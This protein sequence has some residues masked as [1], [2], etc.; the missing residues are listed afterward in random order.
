[1]STAFAMYDSWTVEDRRS[2]M[3]PVR[4]SRR[5]EEHRRRR[6]STSAS[7]STAKVHINVLPPP[8]SKEIRYVQTYMP[9]VVIQSA[10][11]VQPA[12]APLYSIKATAEEIADRICAENTERN[13]LISLEVSLE[14][15]KTL[16][17][18]AEQRVEMEK[19]RREAEEARRQTEK[20]YAEHHS[21]E[22]RE[23]EESARRRVAE[24]YT[25]QSRSLGNSPRTSGESFTVA[26]TKSTSRERGL[27]VHDH[28]HGH[29]HHHHH[30]R[31]HSDS[32]DRRCSSC[33]DSDHR[34]RDCQADVYVPQNRVRH[35]AYLS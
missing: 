22:L 31:S 32:R 9:P 13:K 23:R 35:I 29:H 19:A 27:V 18:A 4:E 12:P 20:I 6:S 11:V 7:C 10:P 1:M 14:E 2:N 5:S 26:V 21:R 34:S 3:V 28:R 17:H 30:H 24:E 16:R 8:P 25:R 15:E 33:G